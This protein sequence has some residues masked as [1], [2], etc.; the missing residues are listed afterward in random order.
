MLK[1]KIINTIVETQQHIKYLLCQGS[2]FLSCH[3]HTSYP[4]ISS[5]VIFI[6]SSII[7]YVKIYFTPSLK[8][9]GVNIFQLENA[10]I[11]LELCVYD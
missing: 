5:I 3:S 10:F 2:K 8:S 11:I 4:R 9:E 1:S 6:V 7:E